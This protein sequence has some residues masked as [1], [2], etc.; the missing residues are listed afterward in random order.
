MKAKTQITIGLITSA[1]MLLFLVY[2]TVFSDFP[3]YFR[4]HI[5][6][7]I[8][9]V[10]YF[11]ALFK[12]KF[13]VLH[14]I[15][16]VWFCLVIIVSIMSG[17]FFAIE[18]LGYLPTGPL[19]WNKSVSGLF[20]VLTIALFWGFTALL[21]TGVRGL[22]QTIEDENEKRI[23]EIAEAYKKEKSQRK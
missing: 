13:A 4:F 18:C 3:F 14:V 11:F 16:R 9:T 5:I 12:K 1:A 7:L 19:D 10:A 22:E 17:I 8:I 23:I 21:W 6:P 20:W 15:Y 2:K